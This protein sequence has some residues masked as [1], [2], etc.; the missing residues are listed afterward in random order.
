MFF[1]HW[2]VAFLSC[3]WLFLLWI[4]SQEGKPNLSL[5]ISYRYISVAIDAAATDIFVLH[6]SLSVLGLNSGISSPATLQPLTATWYSWPKRINMFSV[7]LF[8]RF[9]Q[10]YGI[11]GIRT[12][13]QLDLECHMLS[14]TVWSLKQCNWNEILLPVHF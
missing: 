6:C 10:V 12:I 8:I 1:F 14:L 13:I 4:L 3:L 2:L 5:C 9:Y 11:I 7:S